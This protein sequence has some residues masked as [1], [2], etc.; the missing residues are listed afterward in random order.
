MAKMKKRGVMIRVLSALSASMQVILA[1]V[2]HSRICA[3]TVIEE[4]PELA[5]LKNH[6][7]IKRSL[8]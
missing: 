6:L 1:G 7:T 8:I 4:N 3:D 5:A 2:T